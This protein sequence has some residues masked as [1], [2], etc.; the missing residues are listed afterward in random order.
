MHIFE[1]ALKHLVDWRPVRDLC[2]WSDGGRHFR[3]SVPISTMAY[4]G[5]IH[6]CS[7]SEVVGHNHTVDLNFGLASHFKNAADGAQ[8]SLKGMLSEAAKTEPTISTIPQ[9]LDRCRAIYDL[10]V[11]GSRIGRMSCRFH[12]YFP[13]VE[14]ST[15]ISDFCVQFRS[16]NFKEPIGVC[17]SWKCRL[18]D[19]R[20][21][22]NV[23]FESDGRCLT[24]MNFGAAML[25]DGSR[26]PKERQC[27]PHLQDIEVAKDDDDLAEDEADDQDL[28]EEAGEVFGA[29]LEG[30]GF[31]SMG[32]AV[33]LGW[34]CSYRRSEP[35][36]RKFASW[37][38]R[39]SRQ[40]KRWANVKLQLPKVRR[41]VADQLVLQ[42]RWRIRRRLRKA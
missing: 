10:H 1:Y 38:L 41:S 18:N 28:A 5:L 42:A 7:H 12:D 17:Q 22:K 15:F 6:L 30:E 23:G 11:E 37:R 3:A 31:I 19:K 4:R 20:L 35:E 2:W 39:W 14:R 29:E 33:H 26:I 32:T 8:A 24:A 36:R 27:H 16:F 9:M 13:E 21:K 40:R 25:R 34:K